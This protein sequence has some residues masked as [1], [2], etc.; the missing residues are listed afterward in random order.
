MTYVLGISPL[1]KETTL[2]LFKGNQLLYAVSEERLTRVKQQGGFPWLAFEEMLAVCQ[3]QCEAIEIVAYPFLTAQGELSAIRKNYY[4][5]LRQVV[6]S[7]HLSFT[8][9][10]VSVLYYHRLLADTYRSLHRC[11]R[12]LIEG[13]EKY[14]LEKK[15]RRYDHQL[16]HVGATFYASGFEEALV[17]ISDN[18][19]T[20]TSGGIYRAGLDSINPL[21][22]YQWPNS[23]GL[24]YGRYTSGLGF[25]PDRHE[26]KVLG[27]ASYGDASQLYLDFLK[28]FEFFADGS[29]QHS[30]CLE[31]NRLSETF[32]S[33]IEKYK[34]AD[35]AAALQQ[36][37]ETVLLNSI[38]VQLERTGL[39]HVCLA[40]G[41]MANV[42]LNQRIKELDSVR[43]VFVFP[44]MSDMGAGYGAACL[45][46][47]DL[48][49]SPSHKLEN[50]YLSKAFE[51]SE[52][53]NALEKTNCDF[54][55]NKEIEL[56]VAKLLADHNVV[57]RWNGRMEFGPRALGN[58]SVL[59]N[60]STPDI[61][62]RLS[63][64]LQ[65]TEFMPFAPA[66]IEDIGN[67]SFFRGIE[68]AYVSAQYMTI[69]FDVEP[70]MIEQ[71][72][73]AVHV[74]GTARPQIIIEKLNSSFYKIVKHFYH[75]TGIPAIINTSFNIHEE[76]I[77]YTP[78]DAIRVF[79][80]ARLDYLAIGNFLVK[81][82]D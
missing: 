1:D 6:S 46:L 81:R 66:V 16:C 20:G 33:R 12:Q 42:K 8:D 57:G 63:E 22:K 4:S 53:V 80:D 78:E 52:I 3:V 31:V 43:E 37:L 56:E 32:R 18:Y 58:R 71:I 69:T 41:S 45:A 14:G 76:P 7:R 79:R 62:Q 61:H 74:D 30:R 64:L 34:Q 24:F 10:L 29:F 49:I 60:P 28:E 5:T 38:S 51:S 72:P 26:G 75:L 68:E 21:V 65:R 15:L 17:Q 44:G 36:T 23:L 48:G 47:K 9:R 40:G 55:F 11:D 13:L 39:S 27:L 19:G 35:I 67:N 25:T 82:S 70:K 59:A 2:T 54:T 50:I 73:S 77:V